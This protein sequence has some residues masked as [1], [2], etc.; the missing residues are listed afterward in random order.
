MVV[1]NLANELL[2]TAGWAMVG[3]VVTEAKETPTPLLFHWFLVKLKS[4][5]SIGNLTINNNY[6]VTRWHISTK[7]HCHT[8]HQ[9]DLMVGMMLHGIQQAVVKPHE[10]D[11]AIV[12]LCSH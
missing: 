3:V 9:E 6:N 8:R 5:N 12:C 10:N 1:M 2:G 11:P 7:K 4:M